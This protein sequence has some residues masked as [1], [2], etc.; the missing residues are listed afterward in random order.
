[1]LILMT[2]YSKLILLI[3]ILLTGFTVLPDFFLIVTFKKKYY[4]V[5]KKCYFD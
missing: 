1:M 3:W 4:L 2:L 5:I